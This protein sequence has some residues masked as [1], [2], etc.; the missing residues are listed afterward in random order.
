MGRQ[1]RQE[2]QKSPPLVMGDEIEFYLVFCLKNRQTCQGATSREL[3]ATNEDGIITWGIPLITG[4]VLLW[5]FEFEV[6]EHE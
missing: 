5:L 1:A 4:I 6:A 3:A 2:H